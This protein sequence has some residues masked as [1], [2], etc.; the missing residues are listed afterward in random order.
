[1][2]KPTFSGLRAAWLWTAVVLVAIAAGSY[3]LYLYLSPEPLPEQIVYGNGH[4]EA[5]EVQVAAEVT[6][7]VVASVLVEGTPVRSGDALVQLDSTDLRLERDRA[8]AEIAALAAERQRAASEL[9]MWHH[10]LRT[11]QRDLNRYR[12][13]RERNTVPPQRVEQAEN[14]YQEARGRVAAL[15][16]QI[17]AIEKR[18]VAA[19]AERNLADNRIGKTRITAPLNGTVLVKGV[20]EG[21]FLMAGQTVAVLADLSQMEL[22]V[23]IPEKAIGKFTLGDPARLRVDAFPDRLFKAVIARVDQQAQF[24]PRDIHMPEERVRMVFGVT[25]SVDNA[26]GVLKPGMPADAWILWEAGAAWPDEL[27]VPR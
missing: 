18:A 10:H 24:T 26:D 9:E 13:L 17:E 4:I 7:R 1:M 21:E 15:R 23:Y 20:E 19:V 25:L 3:G 6:G 11:A 5:T 22:K 27:F 12:E 2:T 14:S 8:E 16:S